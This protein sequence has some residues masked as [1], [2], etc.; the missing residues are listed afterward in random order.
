MQLQFWGAAREVTGSCHLVSIGRHRLL[1]DCGL[2]QGRPADETRN[3][4]AFPF[5]PSTIDAVVLTHAHLD[6]SGRLPLLIKAGFKG[7]VYTH[8]A[9]RD[10]CH[11][12]LRDA[13][14]INEKEAEWEN[15][16]RRRRGASGIEPLYTI[17]DAGYA[18]RRF[19][20]M[21]YDDEHEILPGVRI[22]LR[23]AGHILGS[24]IVEMQL[25]E[26]G[27]S[28]K[29]VFSGDLG[30]RG[31]PILRNPATV[32]EADMVVM[33]STYGN[34]L[35]RS[36]DDTLKELGDV[37]NE[38]TRSKGNILIP[39]FTI[40]RTQELLYLF[41]K[42]FSAW[43]LDRWTLFLDSP[44]AIEATEIYNRHTD[45]HD[46]ET[47]AV[48]SAGTLP[49]TPPNLHIS[50]TARQSMSINRIQSGAIII[51][52]SGMCD[53]GRI[54]H[55]LKHNLW[56][57]NCHVII[58]GYQAAGTPGRAMVDGARHIRLWGEEIRVAATIHTVGGLSA[59][60]DQAGLLN[61][62][63]GFKNR[64]RVA[65][66]HGEETALASLESTLKA[67]FGVQPLVPA[68]GTLFDLKTFQVEPPTA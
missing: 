21:S 19:K 35:H 47:Q 37:L 66:V 1:V 65:L 12:M 49:L 61:W 43:G 4:D 5:E 68:R 33:E 23:D 29:I 46:A 14:F 28:R 26:P 59:H 53:G 11:I 50:R 51:A 7:P 56:R 24:S 31:S 58:I 48:R 41:T 25:N 13:G 20:P 27:A 16:K 57:D 55:H 18:L 64:P 22:C 9:T 67:K 2:I 45:L 40:G 42:Y 32:D 34:R 8:H 39:A 60:A 36:W 62:Y 6:H 10:L 63:S 54:K 30:H 17:R 52:G 44:L 3:R 38:A 15:R